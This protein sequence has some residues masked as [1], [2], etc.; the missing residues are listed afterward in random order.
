MI[1]NIVDGCRHTG[2]WSVISEDIFLISPQWR[3]R[4]NSAIDPAIRDNIKSITWCTLYNEN[5]ISLKILIG[6]QYRSAQ[7]QHQRL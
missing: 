3:N 5:W 2:H 7:R 1:V 6:A 4:P